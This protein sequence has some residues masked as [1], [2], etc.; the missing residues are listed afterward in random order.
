M[1]AQTAVDSQIM[2]HRATH[3]FDA[4]STRPPMSRRIAHRRSSEDINAA[5]LL[6]VLMT[7]KVILV[8]HNAQHG[9]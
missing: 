7:E 8:G 2:L 1:Q 6:V 4:G 9:Q 5:R 3:Q